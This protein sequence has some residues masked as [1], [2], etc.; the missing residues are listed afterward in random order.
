MLALRWRLEA[1]LGGLGVDFGSI[2]RR[3]G[4]ILPHGSDSKNSEKNIVFFVF[5][6]YSG[7]FEGLVEASWALVLAMLAPRSHLGAYFGGMLRHVG[8]KVAAKSAKMS[9]HRRQ[10]ANPRGFEGSAGVRDGRD[11]LSLVFC[12][13]PGLGGVARNPSI[14]LPEDLGFKI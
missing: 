13:A 1:P 7:G 10:E 9:Q 5:F 12:N 6:C 14:S 2:W 8:A 11:T 3:F 4:T